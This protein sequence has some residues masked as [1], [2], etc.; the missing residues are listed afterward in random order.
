MPPDS[1][2][3]EITGF[4]NE[5]HEVEWRHGCLWYTWAKN[6]GMSP[7]E[8]KLAPPPQAWE[9]FWRAVEAAGVWQWQEKYVSDICDGTQWSLELKLGDRHVYCY[10]SNAYPGVADA[11]Y[12]RSVQFNQWLRAVRA[13]TGKQAIRQRNRGRVMLGRW[14][15]SYRLGTHR[16]SFAL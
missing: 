9:R 6:P 13:L 15:C 7:V 14:L 3:F 16:R 11:D 12:S 8:T 4:F 5:S 2:H 1:L 10:G